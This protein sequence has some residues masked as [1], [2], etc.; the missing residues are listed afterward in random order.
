MAERACRQPSVKAHGNS[1]ENGLVLRLSAGGERLLGMVEAV[2]GGHPAARQQRQL[3][4]QVGE[5]FHGVKARTIGGAADSIHPGVDVERA[6]CFG[7]CADIMQAALQ[8]VVKVGNRI[9]H[10]SPLSGPWRV[11]EECKQRDKT[12]A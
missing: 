4:G 11:R 1:R 6:Q 9:T 5:P 3:R 8:F 7:P 10:A 2:A 12:G